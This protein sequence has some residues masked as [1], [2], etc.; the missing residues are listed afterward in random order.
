MN[1]KTIKE[2][3][4]VGLPQSANMILLSISFMIINYCV[5]TLGED[6]LNAWSL[7]GRMDEFILM[8]GYALAG[9]T[10][11]LSGQNYGN[12]NISFFHNIF[13]Y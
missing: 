10:L 2:I 12:K 11:T 13:F 4:R 8:V 5:G 9:S 1:F 7:V 6:K 3:V